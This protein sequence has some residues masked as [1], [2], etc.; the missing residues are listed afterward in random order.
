[1]TVLT[2]Y[3]V[4]DFIFQLCWF[5]FGENLENQLQLYFMLTAWR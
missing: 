4:T 1:M 2:W 3:V 5:L